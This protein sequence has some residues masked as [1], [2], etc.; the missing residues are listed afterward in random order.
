MATA[1]RIELE[2]RLNNLRSRFLSP[3]GILDKYILR[4]FC[5]EVEKIKQRGYHVVLDDTYN[6]LVIRAVT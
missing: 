6:K 4:A 3:M 5:R 2:S 1:E